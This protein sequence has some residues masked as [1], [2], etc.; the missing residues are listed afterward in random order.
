MKPL[1]NDVVFGLKPGDL[2]TIIHVIKQQPQI[3][4]ALIFGSRAKGTYKNGS[5]IDI[6]LKGEFDFT[7]VLNI[8]TVLEEDTDLPYMFDILDYNNLNNEKLKQHI[9]RIGIIFY[10][11]PTA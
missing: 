11:K 9:D 10:Q 4:Q 7:T 6:A 3:K 8:K 2:D 1:I 5:D